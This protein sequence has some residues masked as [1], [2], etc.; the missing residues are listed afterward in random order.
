MKELISE[1][2]TA[3][4]GVIVAVAVIGII[5]LM[6]DNLE[7]LNQLNIKSLI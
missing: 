2:G 4:I 6:I 5:W 3:L 7:V 1:Y